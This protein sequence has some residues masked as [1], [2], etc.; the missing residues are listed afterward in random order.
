M[1][2]TQADTKRLWSNPCDHKR[3]VGV[4][5]SAKQ[6]L[7]SETLVNTCCFMLPT[8]FASWLELLSLW[9]VGVWSRTVRMTIHPGRLLESWAARKH[10]V[11][12]GP[13]THGPATLP[14]GWRASIVGTQW[15]QLAKHAGEPHSALHR[16]RRPNTSGSDAMFHRV[17]LDRVNLHVAGAL[18]NA[19]VVGLCEFACAVGIHREKHVF[20]TN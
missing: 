9:L 13:P 20:G 1:Q 10:G 15:A 12:D 17:W 18:P 8:L 2:P 14:A 6:I 3:L 16:P 19:V 7:V 11:W 5:Q 4:G